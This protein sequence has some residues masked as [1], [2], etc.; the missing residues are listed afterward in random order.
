MR[1]GWC[2]PFAKAGLVKDIGYDYLEVPLAGFG[3]QDDASLLAAKKAVAT[4]PIPLTVFNWFY[5]QDF[6]TVGEHV[7]EP[8][9]KSYLKRAA[10]LMHHAGAEAAVLGSAWSRNVPDGFSRGVAKQQI[11]E[12]YGWVAD[13]FKG[14]GVTVGIEAQ[15]PKEANIITSVAEA[16][17]YAKSVNRPEIKI[18]ADF[19]HMDEEKEPL[20]DLKAYADWIIHIQLADTGRRNPGTGSYDYENF[21]RNLKEGGYTGTVSV[22]CMIEISPDQ[23]QRSLKF[24]RRYWST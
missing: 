9:I 21:F 17:A 5:P 20:S 10:E 24:L 12:S 2:A 4:S 14:S 15:N 18:I 7:D 6:R 22:E 23:M 1:L 11:I 3:L 19:Y 16:V 8:R 13:A